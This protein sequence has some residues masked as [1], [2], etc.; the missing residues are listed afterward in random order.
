MK[1]IFHSVGCLQLEILIQ[2]DT[3]TFE[4]GLGLHDLPRVAKLSTRPCVT[5]VAHTR[6]SVDREELN[7]GASSFH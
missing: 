4:K 3:N 5:Q 1:N 2:S 7:L 6:S